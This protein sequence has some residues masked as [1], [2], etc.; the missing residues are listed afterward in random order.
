V[1]SY[2]ERYGKKKYKRSAYIDAL[3]TGLPEERVEREVWEVDDTV[4][5]DRAGIDGAGAD[6]AGTDRM[7]T[8]R[9]G[10]SPAPTF[11]EM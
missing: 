4:G 7:G 10:A 2:A 6:G 3:L 9:A 11:L 8:D 1:L 5:A